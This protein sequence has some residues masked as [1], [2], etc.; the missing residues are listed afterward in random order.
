VAQVR[1]FDFG[2]SCDVVLSESSKFQEHAGQP[3]LTVVEE[4]IT[5]IFF[6]IDIAD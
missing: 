6:E 4:L 3:F 2:V 1:D 5:K